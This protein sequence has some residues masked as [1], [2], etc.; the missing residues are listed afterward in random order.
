MVTFMTPQ[1][2]FSN[3]R[4]SRVRQIGERFVTDRKETVPSGPPSL[5]TSKFCTLRARQT[6]PR[7]RAKFFLRVA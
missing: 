3:H 5:T 6:D 2:S 4:T 1:L 7:D